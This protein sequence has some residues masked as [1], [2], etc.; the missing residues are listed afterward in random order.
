MLVGD[1][2]M[3]FI[4]DDA[5]Q[6]LMV[7]E[8]AKKC[9]QVDTFSGF[10]HNYNAVWRLDIAHSACSDVNRH[11]QLAAPQDKLLMHCNQWNDPYGAEMV[12]FHQRVDE[13]RSSFPTICSL[14]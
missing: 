4:D 5:R 7:V 14:L 1:D 11:A 9:L 3:G 10:Q 8:L 6:H 13:T 12:N 2:Q